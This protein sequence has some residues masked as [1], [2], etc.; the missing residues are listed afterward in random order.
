MGTLSRLPVQSWVAE[1]L[2]VT[3]HSL[4][5]FDRLCKREHWN[6]LAHL[7][8]TWLVA[9]TTK[10]LDDLILKTGESYDALAKRS[11]V[12]RFTLY[13]IREGMIA[14]PRRKTMHA[15]A[16]ALGVSVDAVQK[17]IAASYDAAKKG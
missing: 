11:G 10:T 8:K 9:R 12:A 16:E 17:A 5:H 2:F 6:L 1:G 14:K 13:R 3:W 15:I 4:A 7:P